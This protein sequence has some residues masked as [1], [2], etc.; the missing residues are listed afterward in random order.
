MLEKRFRVYEFTVN[1]IMN[2]SERSTKDS[3]KTQTKVIFESNRLTLGKKNF[4]GKI[5]EVNC[6][7]NK[8]KLRFKSGGNHYQLGV[9]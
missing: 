2:S 3:L 1:T 5:F 7:I 4:R 9:K 8:G 6:L